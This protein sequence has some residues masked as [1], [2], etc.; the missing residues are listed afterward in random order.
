MCNYNV[1]PQTN[2]HIYIPF[3][4]ISAQFFPLIM[5]YRP[6]VNKSNTTVATSRAGIAYPSGAL[7]FIVL[8]ALS[9][10]LSLTTSDYQFGIFKLLL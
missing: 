10:H 2:I 6:N 3:V 5:D 9:D 8:L 4:A 1:N 7:E